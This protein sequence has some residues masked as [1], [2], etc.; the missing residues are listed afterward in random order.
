MRSNNVLAAGIALFSNFAAG[1]TYDP[2]FYNLVKDYG[3]GTSAFFSNFNFFTGTDPKGGFV[4]Y[5]P[6]TRKIDCRFLDATAGA[7][8]YWNWNGASYIAANWWNAA[9]QG[10]PSLRLE[11]KDTFTQVLIIADFNHLPG[12]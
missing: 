1:A 4:K 3:A 6:S 5:P 11:G 10:R 12:P 7:S 9:P 8:M 2:Q